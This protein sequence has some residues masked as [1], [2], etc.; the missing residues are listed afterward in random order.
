MSYCSHHPHN[1]K[2]PFFTK[3]ANNWNDHLTSKQVPANY[4]SKTS[5]N[6]SY[7]M[8]KPI[9]KTSVEKY[10]ISRFIIYLPKRH[11]NMTD[12]DYFENNFEYEFEGVM[13]NMV[14]P[15][16]SLVLHQAQILVQGFHHFL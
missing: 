2:I 12:Q 11:L 5:Y 8:A 7:K 9:S 16:R 14:L 10:C 1:H 13:L 4:D 3:G 6:G 15:S